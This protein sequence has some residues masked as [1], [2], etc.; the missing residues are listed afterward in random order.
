MQLGIFARTY[1]RPSLE[2]TLDAIAADGLTHVHVSLK[3]GVIDQR[4]F[5]RRGLVLASVSGT[6]NSAH[7]DSGRRRE[8]IEMVRRLMSTGAPVVT[9]C[10]G[11]RDAEDMWRRHPSNDLPDA[12]KDLRETLDALLPGAESNGVVLGL[13]PEINNVINT[14][15][16]ARSLLNEMQSPYLKVILDGANLL[17]D[18][19]DGM[20]QT[21]DE[22]FRLL[23]KDVMMV[24]AKDLATPSRPS[25]AA[26][27]GALDWDVYCGLI[28]TY[29][30]QVPVILH[31]LAEHEVASSA[32]FLK[33]RLAHA[34]S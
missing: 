12:W 23:A 27:K 21:L 33:D 28:Q 4:A 6:F 24:H 18:A 31:N 22:A 34:V 30:A 20:A 25:Q 1:T 16:K 5:A 8:G 10:S 2:D 7:P 17:E 3:T 9:L 32:A 14:A 13:E 15:A 26:G 11:T 19:G 29:C